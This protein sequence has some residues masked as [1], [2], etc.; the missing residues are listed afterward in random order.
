MKI[1]LLAGYLCRLALTD[2]VA[3]HPI[4]TLQEREWCAQLMASS[5]PWL[6][7]RRT[8]DAC[9][10]LVSDPSREV[11][12]ARAAGELIGFLILAMMGPF[13]GYIQTVCVVPDRRGG[14]VG[15]LLLAFAETRVFKDSPN[16]FL[17]ASSFNPR[18]RE[19]Y[20]RSG[21]TLIGELTNYLVAAHS[22]LLY[23][24]TR[25]PWNEFVAP[26]S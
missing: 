7:L 16:V 8:I 14:G 17:C 20:E 25:G 19:L 9:R 13:P 5:E 1:G 21:Y 22:E 10:R 18:A 15:S 6:T 4:G 11:Y 23:R 24:K 26:R 12:V 2:S 3:I